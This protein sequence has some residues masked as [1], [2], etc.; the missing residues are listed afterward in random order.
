[1]MAQRHGL[2]PTYGGTLV[3]SLMVLCLWTP[4][5]WNS[6]IYA[7]RWVDETAQGHCVCPVQYA[8]ILSRCS[9]QPW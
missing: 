2:A 1:M 6:R 5:R 8:A 7:P 3:R 9:L 4:Q